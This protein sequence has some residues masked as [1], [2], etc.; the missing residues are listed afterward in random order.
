MRKLCCVRKGLVSVSKCA[1]YDAFFK[2]RPHLPSRCDISQISHRP[3]KLG[4]KVNGARK[5]EKNVLGSVNV[6]MSAPLSLSVAYS[7][8]LVCI[9]ILGYRNKNNKT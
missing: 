5:Q 8:I 2:A 1:R 4:R 7:I 3:P 6:E 9:G